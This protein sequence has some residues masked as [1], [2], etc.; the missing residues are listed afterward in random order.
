MKYLKLIT[1]QY[2]IGDV[3]N[4]NE[5]TVI[6][7]KPVSLEFNPMAGGLSFIPYDAFYLG[8]E[9]EELE[10]KKS[11][12][13]HDFD[14]IPKEIADNYVKF[15]SGIDLSPTQTGPQISEDQLHKL[16]SES[17]LIM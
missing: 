8:K 1:G 2:V 14:D 3:K 6:L 11:H 17:G 16:A 10:I 7:K 5:E 9:I 15:K 12:I 13:M 4:E